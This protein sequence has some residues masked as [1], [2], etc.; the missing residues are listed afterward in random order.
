MHP[1]FVNPAQRYAAEEL[2]AELGAAFLCAE[3]AIDGDMRSAG[4]IAGWVKLLKHDPRAIFTC[5]SRAQAAVDYL[6]DRVLA[7]PAE[8]AE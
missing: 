1:G 8:A 5:A 4:Y 7:A 2:V 6:R 3:F